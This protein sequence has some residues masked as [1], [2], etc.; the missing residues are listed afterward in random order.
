MRKELITE[1]DRKET[2]Y[3]LKIEAEVTLTDL[4]EARIFS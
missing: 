4:L 3:M 2:I 1:C